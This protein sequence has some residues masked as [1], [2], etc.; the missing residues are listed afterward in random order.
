M[1][2]RTT[3]RLFLGEL[4]AVLV[5]VALLVAWLGP[6][7]S[8][9][10]RG[11]RETAADAPLG[12]Q[13]HNVPDGA[14]RVT[15]TGADARAVGGA[16]V[17]DPGAAT[18]VVLR[19][20]ASQTLCDWLGWAEELSAA[21]G[22]RVL[23][24]DRRGQGSTP[25]DDDLAAEPDD[26]AAAVALARTDGAQD[27]VLVASSMGNQSAWAA[28]DRVGDVCAVVSISPVVPVS[29]AEDAI[30][31]PRAVW[32]THEEQDDTIAATA[33]GLLAAAREA[34]ATTHDLAVDTDDHSLA[35][36]ENHDEV[37]DFVTEA[38]ASCA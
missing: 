31:L 37:A 20:G 5:V 29:A 2:R 36:V 27:V 35:L 13:C 26:L 25:G 24:F 8:D 38:V 33:Q 17:G 22:V 30:R 14:T 12:E 3:R 34:G 6:R 9:R 7:V 32:V 11:D 28:V 10:L 21:T 18:A 1:R 19:H 15:L 4:L 16:S 23:L